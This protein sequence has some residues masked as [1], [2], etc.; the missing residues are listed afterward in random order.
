LTKIEDDLTKYDAIGIGPG[1]GT[2]SET[3]AMLR[4]ILDAYR[5]PLVLDAD[6][7]NIISSQKD[8]LQLIPKGSVL[9]PH[10]KEFERLFGKTNNDFERIE[11]A[12]QKAKELQVVIVLKGH[13]SLIAT[14]D[15][16]G[17]FNSTGN[18]GMATAGSG[19]VLTGIITGL[20]A[21]GY[22]SVE[23][24]IFGVYLHGAAGDIAAKKH[25][26]EAM[27]AGDIVESLG[28]AFLLFKSI[29]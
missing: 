29:S 28:E 3:K 24:A 19:D 6:A 17:F 20:L 7:L 21:Q 23:A 10:P 22:S 14:P 1:I 12:L 25:S 2:A 5:S 11:L 9:T 4:E 15:G 26:K 27:L 18:A 16:K 8:F 13:H